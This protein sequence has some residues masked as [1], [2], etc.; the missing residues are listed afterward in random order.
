[1]A[2]DTRV[3]NHIK[4]QRKER[5]Y[6]SFSIVHAILNIFIRMSEQLLS[7]HKENCKMSSLEIQLTLPVE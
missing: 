2:H 3:E 6:F 4:Q 7:I 1:M 5:K